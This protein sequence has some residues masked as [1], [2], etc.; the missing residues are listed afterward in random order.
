MSDPMHKHEMDPRAAEPAMDA[1]P[2][3]AEAP[4]MGQPAVDADPMMAEAPTMGQPAMHEDPTM[5]EAP[6][7]AQ[8]ESLLERVEHLIHHDRK[9]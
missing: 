6:Q 8:H 4:T 9:E 3:M 2:M 7:E 5:A 1:D